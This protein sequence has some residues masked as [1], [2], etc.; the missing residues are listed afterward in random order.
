MAEVAAAQAAALAQA[1]KASGT[2]SDLSQAISSGYSTS[3]MARSS[4][5]HTAAYFALSGTIL[6]LTKDWPSSVFRPSRYHF[7]V[8]SSLSMQ[9][10]SG[11]PV[12]GCLTCA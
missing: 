6:C 9:E 8:E 5:A 4:C 1:I 10:R 2:S 3:R 12:S 11:L 7:Q